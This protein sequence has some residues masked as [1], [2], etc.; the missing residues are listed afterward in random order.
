MTL[1][2]AK[3]CLGL[4]ASQ[5]SPQRDG[6]GRPHL[7]KY[8]HFDYNLSHNG[9]FTIL[10][11]CRDMRVGCDVM[12]IELPRK[13]EFSRPQVEYGNLYIDLFATL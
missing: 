10:T 9:D 3:H 2:A 11:A 5:V 7:P 6:N 4:E 12:K 13:P 1:Y 8:P